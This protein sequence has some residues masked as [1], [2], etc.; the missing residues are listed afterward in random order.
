[1]TEEVKTSFYM[2]KE[3][4]KALKLLHE[5]K[6]PYEDVDN[7]LTAEK[8]AELKSIDRLLDFDDTYYSLDEIALDLIDESISED[9][10]V[11]GDDY[12]K[13]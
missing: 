7:D 2:R 4:I 10:Y 3:I 5:N 9:I 1:M 11:I 13:L 6:I 8:L 12:V